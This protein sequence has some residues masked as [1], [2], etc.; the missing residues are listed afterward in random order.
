MVR[1][2]DVVVFHG[3]YGTMMETVRAATP[4]VV[5]PFHSEQESNGRRLEQNG[6]AVVLGPRDEDLRPMTRRW[7]AG[8]FS[9]L[10]CPRLFISARDLRGAVERVLEGPY[11]AAAQRLSEEQARYGGA[12][13]AVSL[14]LDL[15]GF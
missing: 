8:E 15:G 12:S 7:A 9:T 10:V 5:V 1:Q 4:S 11:R 6:A 3:G 14:L 2:A 13:A